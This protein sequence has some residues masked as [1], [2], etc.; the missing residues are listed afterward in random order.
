MTTTSW[1]IVSF[2]TLLENSRV[3]FTGGGER[4]FM[5]YCWRSRIL[6]RYA[7]VFVFD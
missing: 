6:G 5:S 7:I 2:D 1:H 4:Q 3:I